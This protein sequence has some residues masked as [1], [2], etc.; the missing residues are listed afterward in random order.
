MNY[1]YLIETTLLKLDPTL[2]SHYRNCTVV[3]SQMLARYK[4]SFP[5]YTDHTDLHTLEIVS[6]CNALIGDQ[7]GRLTADDLYVLLMGALF[8]DV[9]MGVSEKDLEAFLR[10][11]APELP[12][13]ACRSDA[14]DLIRK[15]H[16]ELSGWFLEKYWQIFDIPNEAYAEA[17]I[18]VCRGH[19]KVDL[20]DLQT[21]PRQFEV[22]PGR[23][24]SLPYLAALIRL[25]DE[26]DIAAGRNPSFLYD[27]NAIVND[28]SRLAFLTHQSVRSASI[29]P[30]R[31]A[32]TAQADE[33]RVYE[34]VTVVVSKL[35]QVLHH[36][37]KVVDM[38]TDFT[39]RQTGIELTLNGQQFLF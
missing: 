1:D 32:V 30:D 39:V 2:H 14:L 8:H 9:G 27:P 28:I 12:L 33:P 13:P 5:E 6:C 36:C 7:I 25:A 23:T 11:T 17:I 35:A 18:R 24:V 31:I 21:Y 15:H 38:Q 10:D 16:H 19:R 4:S 20:F 29:L 3:S 37:R 26:L 34:E 22:A